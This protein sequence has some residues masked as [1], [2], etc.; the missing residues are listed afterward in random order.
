MKDI[1]DMTL[2]I[3]KLLT[4]ETPIIDDMQTLITNQ[5]SLLEKFKITLTALD[6]TAKYSAKFSNIILDLHVLGISTGRLYNA[7]K[8]FVDNTVDF[9]LIN[10]NTLQAY[11][12]QH[13]FH[14]LSISTSYVLYN[15]TQDSY[16]I[17]F[18][19]YALTQPF[20]LYKILTIPLFM[21]QIPY[22]L[23]GEKLIAINKVGDVIKLDEYIDQCHKT[24]S[25]YI[26]D[27]QSI[28]I[29]INYTSCDLQILNY[30]INPNN[31]N[32]SLCTDKFRPSTPKYQQYYIIKDNF[33]SITSTYKDTAQVL[34]NNTI[35]DMINLNIGSTYITFQDKIGCTLTTKTTVI[36][37]P[38]EQV[39]MSTKYPSDDLAILQTIED[40]DNYIKTSFNLSFGYQEAVIML[41]NMTSNHLL[42][43]SDIYTLNDH[44][45][46]LQDTQN[47][48][49]FK[50]FQVNWANIDSPENYLTII[51]WAITII[52][53]AGLLFCCV[54]C[55]SS[56]ATATKCLCTPCTLSFKLVKICYNHSKQKNTGET[57]QM[58]TLLAQER[59]RLPIVKNMFNNDLT[60]D[61]YHP[62]QIYSSSTAPLLDLA[63][64]TNSTLN[65]ANINNY[66]MDHNGPLGS[67]QLWFKSPIGEKLL[68]NHDEQQFQQTNGNYRIKGTPPLSVMEVFKQ[69]QDLVDI[70]YYRS[71]STNRIVVTNSP[72][73]WYVNKGTG[74][75]VSNENPPPGS[76][77]FGVPVPPYGLLERFYNNL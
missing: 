59:N 65:L 29:Q 20:Q 11:L 30:K 72:Q 12:G 45:H 9:T 19:T 53:L 51:F 46:R 10:T 54:S 28:P 50:P 60:P 76:K 6:A 14:S 77:V 41:K 57:V 2:D 34:C 43:N 49:A 58:S 3:N 61:P 38:T 71:A 56:V 7:V 69:E 27:P 73:Y 21:N 31:L 55:Y 42:V 33:V 16:T 74:Y 8:S 68:Y 48:A 67:L 35:T 5:E 40:L 70:T 13:T 23:T 17:M 37:L 4:D 62:A 64:P 22:S 63:Q 52:T 47:S 75:I 26:C 32:L 39:R 66:T 1:R 36:I 25:D 15:A 24:G 18:E 44:V